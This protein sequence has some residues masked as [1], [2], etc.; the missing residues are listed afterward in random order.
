MSAARKDELQLEAR[1]SLERQ[2]EIEAK[3][4]LSLD[5]YLARYFR[6]NGSRFGGSCKV[7]R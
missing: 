5:E 1:Q 3:D 2:L 6:E 4:A 7:S